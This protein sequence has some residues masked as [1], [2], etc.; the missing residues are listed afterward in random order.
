MREFFGKN[1]LDHDCGGGYRT[2]IKAYQSIL[3]K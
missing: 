1:I 2:F 3:L